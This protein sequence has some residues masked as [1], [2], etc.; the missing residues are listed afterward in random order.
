[1][2]TTASM[3]SDLW[4]GLPVAL[5]HVSLSPAVARGVVEDMRSVHQ[6]QPAK[7]HEACRQTLHLIALDQ[8]NLPARL[9]AH[10]LQRPAI[11]PPVAFKDRC[12]WS[13]QKQ[14]FVFIERNTELWIIAG[15]SVGVLYGVDEW[16]RCRTGVI[17][18]GLKDEDLLFGPRSDLP[19]GIQQPAMPYRG[20][21][22][23]TPP[24]AD[25]TDYIRWLG[26]TRYNIWRR[27]S[28]WWVK[29][30]AS[31]HQ[32]VFDLCEQRG[33][34]VTLGDHAMDLF[35]PAEQFETHPEWFGMRDG[36]RVRRGPVVMP[37]CPHL[38]ATLPIQPCYS[39]ESLA[40]Y[41]TDAM[42]SHMADFP[43]ASMFG[44][45]PHDGVNN[46]CQC[47]KCTRRTP[48]EHMYDLAM[49]LERKL[50]ASIPIELIAYS[51]LIKLPYRP[52]PESDRTFTMLCPYLRHFHHRIYEPYEG[53]VVTGQLYPQPDRINPLDDRE[54]GV[55][56]SKWRQVCEQAGSVMA[57]FEYGSTYYDETRRTDR[58]RLLYGPPQEVIDDEILWYLMQ[59]VKVYY[60]CS[61]FRGWPDLWH[62]LA[63]MET[64]WLGRP[65]GPVSQSFYQ[66]IDP[67]IG[68]SLH[69][70]LDALQQP[71]LKMQEMGPAC[72]QLQKVLGDLPAS[73]RVERYRLWLRYLKM[74]RASWHA[75]QRGQWEQVV[76]IEADIRHMLEFNRPL[77]SGCLHVNQIVRL[78]QINADRAAQRQAGVAGK[79]YVL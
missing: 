10:G 12:L 58:P 67:Q 53:E 1:M 5:G 47:E 29:Q 31:Y 76:A 13:Q 37:E 25:L 26:R 44:L 62:E 38:N 71:M 68:P 21:D 19:A 49:R 8:N 65:G 42:A 20:R 24:D 52:L 72:D 60:L 56:F 41:L 33:I 27:S 50:P 45:W 23:S 6:Q 57:I 7:L 17:W 59:G 2:H 51:N 14:S 55:L 16:L 64:L 39:N 32:K 43:R 79:Q 66:A 34:E 15:S 11:H 63:T 74:A 70:A 46:W 36:Q 30:D 54:Y 61:I 9:P 35:L 48:F 77:I 78:S 3:T 73:P 69:K 75:E 28:A 40:E 18:A 22:G 4:T